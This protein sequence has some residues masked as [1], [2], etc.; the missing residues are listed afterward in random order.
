MLKYFLS[1][2]MLLGFSSAANE[3]CP[4]GEYWVSPHSRK[5]Y[6]KLDGTQV[7]AT[8]VTGHCRSKGKIYDFWSQSFKNGVIEGWPHE[9]EKLKDWAGKEIETIL[10]A[11]KNVP[12]EL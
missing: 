5:A 4:E 10:R 2:T 12:R 3:L 11:L 8:Y 1:L 9:K 6:E 7:S